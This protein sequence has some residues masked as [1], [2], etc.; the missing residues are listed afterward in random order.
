MGAGGAGQGAEHKHNT[1]ATTRAR[2][3]RR[4]IATTTPSRSLPRIQ[5]NNNA[6]GATT[7]QVFDEQTMP[8]RVLRARINLSDIHME[9]MLGEGSF[10]Q[11]TRSSRD[12]AEIWSRYIRDAVEMRVSPARHVSRR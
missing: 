6:S 5:H 1:A 2:N 7:T 12:A 8:P 10:G 3:S 9:H 4:A 11:A